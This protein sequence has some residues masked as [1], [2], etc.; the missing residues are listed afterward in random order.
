MKRTDLIKRLAKLAK[1]NGVSWSL[2]RE[3]GDHSIYEFN[4]HRIPVPRH[5]EVQEGTA[6]KIIRE[7]EEEL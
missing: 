1:D 6:R 7:A 3:G 4:G 5:R 2:V